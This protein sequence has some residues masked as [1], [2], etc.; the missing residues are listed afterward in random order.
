M[1]P[2]QMDRLKT[3]PDGNGVETLPF[4]LP[5]ELTVRDTEVIAALWEYADGE[6]RE[7]F[8]LR[9]L[10]IGV[11]ALQQA[12]GQI[13]AGSVRQEGERLLRNVEGALE[14]HQQLLNERMTSQLKDYFD[15]QNG[16]FQERVERLIRQDGELEQVLRRNIGED[17]SELCRTLAAHI[18]EQSPVMQLLDPEGSD[19]LTAE[20]RTIVEERLHEQRQRLLE[21]FSLDTEEGALCRFLGELRKHY[22]GVSGDLSE[23]IDKA[24]GEFS[25]DDDTSALSR[26]VTRVKTAQETIT[27]EFSLDEEKSALSR[28][29]NELTTLLKDQTKTNQEFQ[30]EV[31]VAIREL[32]A[33]KQEADQSTRHGLSFE[34]DLFAFVQ[35][36]AARTGDVAQSTNAT[37]GLIKNSKVGDVVLELGPESAAPSARIV[38]EAKES[39][40]YDLKQALAEVETAR[41]NRGAQIGVFVF[42]Q[43]TAP[44]GLEPL[45]RFG[46]D[47][48]VVWDAV[49][50]TSDLYL[51][52]AL[53][54]AR[55]LCVRDQQ[56]DAAEAADLGEIDKAVLEIEKRAG[57]LDQ[58]K[59]SA[60]TIINGAEKIIDRQRKIRK[61]LDKQVEGLRDRT[62]AL[63]ELLGDDS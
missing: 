20:L 30:E 5:L 17:D 48:V 41:K 43:K 19:G 15:P 18:G 57:E 51:K 22:D 53:T 33:R 56:R 49:D 39:A 25:L 23:K 11:L 2:Q 55:A 3:A 10:R 36:D 1:A 14:K 59:K 61:S 16:R 6:S 54:L 28:L 8:A 46:Q 42:S 47:I 27:K 58:I 26:L 40:S 52:V 4:T 21:Q 63:R 7:E 9:A 38:L 13:D 37:T 31:K 44:A 34:E 32:Q 24:V 35:Q 29:R 60:E 45:A 50:P 12:Q 62:A